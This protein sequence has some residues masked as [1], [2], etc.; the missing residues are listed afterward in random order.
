VGLLVAGCG[1]DEARLFV[2]VRTDFLPEREFVRAVV[3]VTQGESVRSDMRLASADD[4]YV[5]GVRVLEATLPAGQRVQ[6]EAE[7]IAGDGRVI[8]ERSVS[9]EVVETTAVTVVLS[10]MPGSDCE[11]SGDCEAAA[12]CVTGVCVEGV[13]FAEVDDTACAAG[14]RCDPDRGC[15]L[16][17]NDAGTTDSGGAPD[18]G[19]DGGRLCDPAACGVGTGCCPGLSGC[20]ELRSEMRCGGCDVRCASGQRC[21]HDD[22]TGTTF[23]TTCR[24]D[25]CGAFGT[26]CCPATAPGNECTAF[27]SDANNCGGCGIRCPAGQRCVFHG[28]PFV[29]PFCTTC[30]PDDCGAFGTICCPATAPGNE[31]TPFLSDENNCGGCEVRCPAGQTCT[32]GSCG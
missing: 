27:L 30:N 4:P 25:D 17:A 23:C 9:V 15:E 26:I 18:G 24:P 13:C 19:P 2:D 3:R 20:V 1:G 7:L 28:D 5:R 21:L 8:A 6:L 22:T 31:C 14:E 11:T 32:M 29:A 10:R 12:A 16:P